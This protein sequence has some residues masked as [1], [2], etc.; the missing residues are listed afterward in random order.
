MPDLN[1]VVKVRCDMCGRAL[2]VDAKRR[3][4]GWAVAVSPCEACIGLTY[5]LGEKAGLAQTR[6]A[7]QAAK[8]VDD[9]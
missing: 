6:A 9:G 8:E 2:S 1:V 4:W 3:T 7:A 5:R